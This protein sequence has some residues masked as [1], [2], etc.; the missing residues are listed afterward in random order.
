MSENN[1]G[2][3]VYGD[4]GSRRPNISNSNWQLKT[5]GSHVYRILPPF[6]V[7]AKLGRWSQY[8]A[9]HWGFKLSNGKHRAFRCILRKKRGTNLVTQEC[10]MCTKMAQVEAD[11]KAKFDQMTK[12]KKSPEEI[13]KALEPIEAWQ[14]A[15]NLQKGHFLNVLSPDGQIGRLFIKIRCKQSL[16]KTLASI[17]S[18]EGVDPIWA[19]QGVWLDFQRF[20]AGRNDTVYDVKPAYEVVEVN[21]R[22]LKSVKNAPLSQDTI[23]RMTTEAWDLATFYRDLSFDE[24][25][26]LVSSNG[27]PQIMDSLFGMPVTAKSEEIPEEDDVSGYEEPDMETPAEALLEEAKKQETAVPVSAAEQQLLAQLAALRSTKTKVDHTP[28]PKPENDT[29]RMT[30]DF[31]RTF[32]KPTT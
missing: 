15:F 17:I 30:Q 6:G 12:S 14:Q 7:L 28:T 23:N 3:P 19:E 18:E 29:D 31:L 21:G 22:K 27:D 24:I 20:G 10:P 9:L 2:K 11:K 32:G 1:I 5:Q 16:D 25:Q 8:E 13:S 4:G 26:M